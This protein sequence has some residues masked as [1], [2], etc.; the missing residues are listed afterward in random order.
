[1]TT[2][3]FAGLYTG[4]IYVIVAL[5]YN[6]TLVSSGVL[7]FAFANTLVLGGFVALSTLGWGW[8]LPLVLLGCIVVGAASSVVV[9]RAAIRFMPAGAHAEL[10][11]TLGA[12]TMITGITAVI[13]GSDPQRLVLYK[14][15]AVDLLGGRVLPNNLV[16]IGLA[17][18]LAVGMHLLIRHTRLG[19][20]SRAQAFDREA[21][22]LRG[23]DVRWLSIG[24]FALAGA[25][26]GLAGPF[27]LMTEQANPFLAISLALKGFVALALGGL[28]SDLGA[29]LAGLCIGLIEAYVNYFVGPYY[30]EYAVFAV[31]ALVL[32]VR[33]QG[34]FGHRTLR[35][36]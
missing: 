27:V 22:M 17:V 18:L 16:L 25:I 4:A 12:G 8:P 6:L 10:I 26:A 19:L 28:G 24:A 13:W 34:I 35:L 5:G 20:S 3:T 9:E 14:Q 1:M 7:N 15:H 33:P 23:I 31:F 2:A 36:V 11:T 29:L 30:G 21:A 32:L